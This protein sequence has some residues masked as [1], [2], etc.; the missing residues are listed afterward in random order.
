MSATTSDQQRGAAR[1]VRQAVDTVAGV[2]GEVTARLPE[3]AAATREGIDE[4]NRIVRQGSDQT[5]RIVVGTSVGFASGLFLGGAPRIL[6]LTALV[7][8]ALAGMAL[9]E[10][11]DPELTRA[12]KVR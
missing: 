9:M 6:V 5:L 7:P 10:R 12:T 8:A 2:A 1:Q 11:I 4:A 3:A